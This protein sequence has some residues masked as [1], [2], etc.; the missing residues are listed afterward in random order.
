MNHSLTRVSRRSL[1]FA[2][3]LRRQNVPP[4]VVALSLSIAVM[5]ACGGGSAPSSN[6]PPPPTPTAQTYTSVKSGG[7]HDSSVWTPTGVPKSGDQV[8]LAS[9]FTVTCESAQTC[10]VGA[11]PAVNQGGSYAIDC[12]TPSGNGVL[13]VAGTLQFQG[14][15]R[16]CDATWTVQAGGSLLHDNTG[17]SGSHYQWQICAAAGSCANALLKTLGTGWGTG[18]SVTITNATG[19]G[20]FGGFT[21]G[22]TS[23]TNEISTTANASYRPAGG[24]V[25]GG[26]IDFS[27]TALT[28]LGVEG[29]P[30]GVQWLTANLGTSTSRLKMDNVRGTG[31]SGAFT[32]FAAGSSGADPAAPR[33][34]T[35]SSP[36]P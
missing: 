5:T 24:L 1:Q 3:N 28:N 2:R 9:G 31:L 7:W 20:N 22:S 27:Y 35:H 29:G 25:G 19:A 17:N 10:V 21:N 13:N 16:Q 6:P 11:S 14:P 26:N 8:L 18:L 32:V 12:T 34:L 33:P 15:V 23:R 30:N 36:P 4:V